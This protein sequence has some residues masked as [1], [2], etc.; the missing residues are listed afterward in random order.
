MFRVPIR[1]IEVF[2]SVASWVHVSHHCSQKTKFCIATLK[3]PPTPNRVL[4][5]KSRLCC[6]MY[7]AVNSHRTVGSPIFIN[8]NK[9]L[10]EL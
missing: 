7:G 5:D 9:A 2:Q 8:L 3:S 6:V 4:L 10:K 1:A